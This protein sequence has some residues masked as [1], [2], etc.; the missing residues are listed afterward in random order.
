MGVGHF[1]PPR[2]RPPTPNVPRAQKSR[3]SGSDWLTLVMGGGGG[4]AS[5]LTLLSKMAE[6]LLPKAN[7]QSCDPKKRCPEGMD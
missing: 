3:K 1:H 5:R 4:G 2:P 7:P 6:G